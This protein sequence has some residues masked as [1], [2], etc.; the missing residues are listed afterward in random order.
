VT[1]ASAAASQTV[2]VSHKW[3]IIGETRKEIL[4]SAQSASRCDPRD[5]RPFFVQ[6]S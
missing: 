3:S 5:P 4:E 6:R 1:A 2:N